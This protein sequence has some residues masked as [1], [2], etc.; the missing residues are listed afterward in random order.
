MVNLH[1]EVETPSKGKLTTT[2]LAQQLSCKTL[3]CRSVYDEKDVKAM[4]VE[5]LQTSF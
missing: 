1:N 2:V 5:V 4:F 3:T